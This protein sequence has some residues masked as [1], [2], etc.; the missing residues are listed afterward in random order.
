M[1]KQVSEQF[2]QGVAHELPSFAFRKLFPLPADPQARGGGAAGGGGRGGRGGR[3]RGEG[4]NIKG[5]H[6][7]TT[8]REAGRLLT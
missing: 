3:G 5:H 1:T 4:Y 6:W 8:L 7:A 2:S